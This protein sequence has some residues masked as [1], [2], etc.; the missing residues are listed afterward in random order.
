MATTYSAQ[1]EIQFDYDNQAWIVNGR[2]VRCGHIDDD[3]GC[4]G[5]AHEGEQAPNIH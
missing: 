3:C 1:D 5:K 2:Y 4:Y